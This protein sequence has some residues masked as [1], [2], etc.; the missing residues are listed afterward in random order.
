MAILV[1]ICTLKPAT[2]HIPN[3]SLWLPSPVPLF[4]PPVHGCLHPSSGESLYRYTPIPPSLSKD[5][6]YI[7]ACGLLQG[8]RSKR[9]CFLRSTT[10]NTGGE[11]ESAFRCCCTGQ[12]STFS[13]SSIGLFPVPAFHTK[14]AIPSWCCGSRT[15]ARAPIRR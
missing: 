4:S 5:K 7:S 13:S 6:T 11:G 10:S 14:N 2:L 3:C 9:R 1:R 12:P 15:S 8:T